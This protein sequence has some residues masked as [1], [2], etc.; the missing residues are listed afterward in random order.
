[1]FIFPEME[2]E[3]PSCK[4]QILIPDDELTEVFEC[5]FCLQTIELE[6][7]KEDEVLPP[8]IDSK[9]KPKAS[10]E[11]PPASAPLPSAESIM[12]DFRGPLLMPC[13]ACG[14]SVSKKADI[15]AGCGHPIYSG[16]LGTAGTRRALNIIFLAAIIFLLFGCLFS[17]NFV[18]RL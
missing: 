18:S 1:M 5:P 9:E 7:Q 6:Q 15:C 8:K 16:F 11:P 2:I 4:E 14:K 10:H 17:P 13:P 3:C 12:N